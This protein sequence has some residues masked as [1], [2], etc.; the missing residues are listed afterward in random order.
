MTKASQKSSNPTKTAEAAISTAESGPELLA[1]TSTTEASTAQEPSKTPSETVPPEVAAS[2]VKAKKAKEVKE[3]PLA[4]YNT[5]V[6]SESEEKAFVEALDLF[7]RNWRSVSFKAL[8]LY[9]WQLHCL[10]I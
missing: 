6:Y 5:G 8:C 10:G 7:G 4:R 3:A 9:V 1:I 2:P